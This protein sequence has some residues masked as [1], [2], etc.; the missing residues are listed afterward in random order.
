MSINFE[1]LKVPTDRNIRVTPVLSTINV[2][3][4]SK[5]AFFQVRTGDGFEPIQ[6]F[7]Y[8]PEG[9]GKDNTPYLVMPE[10]QSFLQD[11][12]VLVPAKFYLYVIYGSKIMKVDFVSQKTDKFGNL[13]R[14]HASRMEAYEV[15]KTKWVR[16]YANQEGG[17]YSY[18]FAEDNL[19]NPVWPKKPEN[20]QEAIEIAFKGFVLD[21]MDH[22]IIKTLR[23]KQ[24]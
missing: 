7:T 11:L 10:C 16:M 17:Y 2:G 12:G 19:D 20:I 8:T 14:Y 24:L 22:P 21:S 5:T 6:L 18:A 3:K 23:G 1:A 13:N 9:V 4:P 15:A